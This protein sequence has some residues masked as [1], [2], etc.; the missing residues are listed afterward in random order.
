MKRFSFWIIVA[1][2][3]FVI[4]LG[5]V[6]TWLYYNQKEIA[7]VEPVPLFDNS[8]L[9]SKSFPG[10]SRKISELQKG[11]SGYFP[12]ETFLSKNWKESDD[13]HNDW[14]GK[15]LRIMDEKPLLDISDENTEVYRF[16]WLRTFHHPI[17]VRVE[18]NEKTIRLF[19]K[20]LDGA[21]GYDSRK[22]IKTTDTILDESQWCQF[23]NLLEKSKYWQM[24]TEDT[25]LSGVD[26]AQWILE[27]VKDG[28]YHIV[29]RFMPEKDNYGQACIYLLQLSGVDTDR[30]KH[31][32][33]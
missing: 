16:L 12:N 14:Y 23:L 32:L 25:R 21:G 7:E 29:D 4:G 33:Y 9:Q 13:F 20:E 30:L 2:F 31:E 24:P 15:F 17:F 28:R 27:G 19:S 22:T 1:A 8:C 26:G 10:L 3:T 11:K 18:R 6:L 5:A